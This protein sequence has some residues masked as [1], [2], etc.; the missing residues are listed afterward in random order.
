MTA[1]RRSLA[2]STAVRPASVSLTR[3][4]RESSG[5]GSPAGEAGA[6]ELDDLF[7]GARHFDAEVPG[8]FTH[9]HPVGGGTTVAGSGSGVHQHLERA[10]VGGA[11]FAVGVQAADQVDAVAEGLAEILGEGKKAGVS[12]FTG[13]HS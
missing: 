4:A 8:D 12:R 10:E 13:V 9:S 1:L 7:G 5:S 3:T 6:L 11:E 2:D